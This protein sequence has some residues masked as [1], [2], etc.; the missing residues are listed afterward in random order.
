MVSMKA[1]D[2]A[3]VPTIAAVLLA[4]CLSIPQISFAVGDPS[5]PVN[6]GSGACMANDNMDT[7][8]EGE[9]MAAGSAI[10]VG[11]QV[12]AWT[13]ARA[14]CKTKNMTAQMRCYEA[15]SATAQKGLTEANQIGSTIAPSQ[16]NQTAIKT[17]AAAKA[18]QQSMG[19]YKVEC[20][21]AK[22]ECST[23]C[24]SAEKAA[25]AA[26][27]AASAVVCDPMGD[28]MCPS[29]KAKVIAAVSKDKQEAK[30]LSTGKKGQCDKELSEKMADA[31]EMLK[32]LMDM[33][34]SAAQ[35]QGE[36]D[37]AATPIDPK[38]CSVA[39]NKET[40]YCICVADPRLPGCD[41]I[42]GSPA[43]TAATN[44]NSNDVPL[45]KPQERPEPNLGAPSAE[46]LLPPSDGDSSLNAAGMMAGGNGGPSGGSASAA[47]ADNK[48]GS[49]KS[50][51]SAAVLGGDSGGGGGGGGWSSASAAKSNSKSGRTV[52]GSAAKTT[53]YSNQVTGPGGRTNWYKVKERY[54]DNRPTFL[55]D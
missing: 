3:S 50:G 32:G 4:L 36:S 20:E 47:G 16:T 28:P 23:G 37:Q 42:L 55:K 46:S 18:M 38:D 30:T 26:I 6:N 33:L 29:N 14:A 2:R 34:Q 21:T 15:C 49:N 1:N 17:G 7:S 13:K 43:N 52:A 41:A 45:I 5:A 27:Q 40:Q 10:G 25:D 35:T 8:I 54:I 22:K 44:F 11:G 39:A 24:G 9:A 12:S 19:F 53:Q 51:L 48:E 31:L